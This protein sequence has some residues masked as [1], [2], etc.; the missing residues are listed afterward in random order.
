[1]SDDTVAEAAVVGSVVGT[2]SSTDPDSGDTFTYSLVEG[3][4]DTDNT[5]FTIVGDELQ[6][7]ITFDF[8]TQSTYS[9]RV[10]SMD[11]GGLSVEQLLTITV[12]ET[13]VAPTAV[14]LDNTS[15]DE[16][17]AIGTLVGTLATTDANSADTHTYQLVAGPGD[18]DNGSFTVDGNQVLTAAGLD[19]ETQDSYS[20]RVQSTD[21]FGL[22]VE[23]V[24]V[25]TVNDVNEAPTEVLL[26]NDT[27]SEDAV[28]GTVVGLLTSS[29]PDSGNTHTYDLVAR[30]QYRQR[31]IHDRG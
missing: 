9:I 30:W 19:F 6:T 3:V 23:A 14:T 21:S 20:I 7:A 5:A 13:N 18:T 28:I 31:I 24:L 15:V 22:T 27:V 11:Q 10:Q 1:M 12:I 4:G 25:I 29:D 17:A 2:L 8:N 26:S 16:N